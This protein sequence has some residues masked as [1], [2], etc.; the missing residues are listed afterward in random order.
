MTKIYTRI[1]F[2][3]LGATS[4]CVVA[5]LVIMGVIVVASHYG[6]IP[7]TPGG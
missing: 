5:L 3:G 2:F 1:I 4:A 6:W 7:L